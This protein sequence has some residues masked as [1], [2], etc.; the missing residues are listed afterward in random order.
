M[1]LSKEELL[2]LVSAL[3][4]TTEY[5]YTCRSEEE[6]EEYIAMCELSKK[7]SEELVEEEDDG[8]ELY[9]KFDSETNTYITKRVDNTAKW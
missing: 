5:G 4:Y 1:D 6:E 2:L 7:V 8:T 9:I 3:N